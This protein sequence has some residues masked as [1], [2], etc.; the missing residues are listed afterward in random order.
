MM[1]DAKKISLGEE[2]G[3]EDNLRTLFEL[4]RVDTKIAQIIKL[5]GEL[6]LEVQDLEDEIEGLRT[7]IG[8]L[9]EDIAGNNTTANRM[10][11]EIKS[12]EVQKEKLQEQLNNVRNNREYDSLNKEIRYK[13]LEIELRQKR[14]KEVKA[15]NDVVSESIE[16]TRTVMTEREHDLEA[17]R[18]ELDS[19]IEE[20][21]K[22][23]AELVKQSEALQ[24]QLPDRLLRAY[25]RICQNV[26][27]G[28]G[29]VSIVRDA[30]GGCFNRIPPQRQL[31]IRSHKRV[32]ICEYC[33]RII[34]DDP[35]EPEE[36]ANEEE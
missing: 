28:M 3:I 20:T 27:N 13:D 36:N 26:R 29:V 22:E 24:A 23:E 12:F 9:D 8:K 11:H 14:I 32:I 15:K 34:V 6:P 30:C 1:S 4:Q 5:R 10:R 31:D 18:S 21:S 16:Q 7:R 25:T 19:I 33:G 2:R 35:T 17:K